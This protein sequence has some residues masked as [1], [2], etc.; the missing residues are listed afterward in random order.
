MSID[1]FKKLYTSDFSTFSITTLDHYIHE[2]NKLIAN[3]R[4]IDPL[5]IEIVSRLE[6]YKIKYQGQE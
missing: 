1:E 2:G 5:V 3:M 6:E 4:A